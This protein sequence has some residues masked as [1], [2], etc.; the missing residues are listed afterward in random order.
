MREG[1]SVV[2]RSPKVGLD[3]FRLDC[4]LDTKFELIEAE[5]GLKGFAVV[6]KLFQRIYGGQGYYCEWDEDV[7][8]VFGAKTGLGA[9]V[10]SEIVNAAIKR[11]LFDR[12]K[13]VK[14]HI[15]TSKGIQKWYFEAINRRERV[16]VIRDYLFDSDVNLPKNVSI[17]A[18]SVNINPINE[19]RNPQSIAE[20]SKGEEVV[21]ERARAQ[22]VYDSDFARVIRAYQTEIGR[23]PSGSARELLVSYYEDFGADAMI[24]AIKETNKKQ[25]Y[26]PW[27]YLQSILRAFQ[28]AGVHSEAEAIAC[29]KDHA[30]RVNASRGRKGRQQ[31]APPSPD[32]YKL[33]PGDNPFA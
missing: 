4:H 1:D 8:L 28:E 32:A 15:L 18:I 6:V 31:E 19:D 10:V 33:Q 25:A 21:V 24:V 9:S 11:E 20:E 23:D 5:F 17:K 2:G 27:G 29:C 16:E 3:Y 12:D 7:A 14:Y 30:R 22:G 26:S 13:F